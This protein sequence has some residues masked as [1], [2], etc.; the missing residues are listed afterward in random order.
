MR[1]QEAMKQATTGSSG[2]FT[3]ICQLIWAVSLESLMKLKTFSELFTIVLWSYTSS[4]DPSESVLESI[5]SSWRLFRN[6]SRF[7]HSFFFLISSGRR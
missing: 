4:P 3:F 7:D 1:I 6:K 5:Q 2:N